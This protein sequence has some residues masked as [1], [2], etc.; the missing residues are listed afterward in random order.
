MPPPIHKKAAGSYSNITSPLKNTLEKSDF[1]SIYKQNFIDMNDKRELVNTN[2]LLQNSR[3]NPTSY[4][5][6]KMTSSKVNAPFADFYKNPQTLEKSAR[7]SS[8]NR[9]ANN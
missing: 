4:A 1:K 6:P 3:V 8:K 9:G 2:T 5:T 7:P